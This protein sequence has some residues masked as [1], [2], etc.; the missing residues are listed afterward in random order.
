MKYEAKISDTPIHNTPP[1][2]FKHYIDKI[3]HYRIRNNRDRRNNIYMKIR[4][5]TRLTIRWMCQL[6]NIRVLYEKTG[7]RDNRRLCVSFFFFFLVLVRGRKHRPIIIRI[8]YCTANGLSNTII[9]MIIQYNRIARRF[10]YWYVVHMDPPGTTAYGKILPWFARA[11]SDGGVDTA[12]AVIAGVTRQTYTDK[13]VWCMIDAYNIG[14]NDFQQ[15]LRH[16]T[17]I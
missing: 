2:V 4:T 3:F 8:L 5:Y 7:F 17:S 11:Y 10:S 12:V 9:T 15:R 16:M 1:E 13:T 6:S 14:C